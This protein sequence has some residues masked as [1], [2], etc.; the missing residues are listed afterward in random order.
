MNHTLQ[1][2]S[3]QLSGMDPDPAVM[4]IPQ[5]E[6][7]HFQDLLSGKDK[8]S[9]CSSPLPWSHEVHRL[10]AP[11]K[12]RW[13]LLWSHSNMTSVMTTSSS[14][15]A[16]CLQEN[17]L[18][19]GSHWYLICTKG[20][21]CSHTSFMRIL[22]PFSLAVVSHVSPA[23]TAA[24]SLSLVTP[25]HGALTSHPFPLRAWSGA[26][27]QIHI[28][29]SFVLKSAF[30]STGCALA[31]P[32]QPLMANEQMVLM[33]QVESLH[34]QSW[35]TVTLLFPALPKLTKNDEKTIK[36]NWCFMLRNTQRHKNRKKKK[37]LYPLGKIQGPFADT[38][39]NCRNTV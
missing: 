16:L 39:R 29:H 2:P 23:L 19:W 17:Q 13:C 7:K 27:P 6:G 38:N 9:T 35:N 1:T 12:T 18:R 33:F 21:L 22:L 34:R 25:A 10:V 14:L 8:F 31:H 20:W 30:S 26:F 37:S 36:V 28:I 3:P 4:S 32:P 15:E 5:L 24:N 11:N